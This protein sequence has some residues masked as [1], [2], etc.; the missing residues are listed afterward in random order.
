MVDGSTPAFA[1]GLG[2]GVRR[3]YLARRAASRA[4]PTKSSTTASI[5]IPTR[6]S[7]A[8]TSRSAQYAARFLIRVYL[9]FNYCLYFLAVL[10]ILAVQL[11]SWVSWRLGGSIIV[12]VFLASLASWRLIYCDTIS[13]ARPA[14]AFFRSNSCTVSAS[15]SGNVLLTTALIRLCFT[16]SSVRAISELFT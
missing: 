3:R 13:A 9:R 10:A 12:L 11:L 16:S 15:S 1:V 6:M 8:I 5:M 2:R 14:I 7:M 4:M